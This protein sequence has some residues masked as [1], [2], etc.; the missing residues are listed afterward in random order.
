MLIHIWFSSFFVF[1]KFAR[2][3]SWVT[4]AKK[5][6]LRAS[7]AFSWEHIQF[8]CFLFFTLYFPGSFSFFG[9]SGRLLLFCT[10]PFFCSAFGCMKTFASKFEIQSYRFPVFI[11]SSFSSI[12]FFLS[13]VSPPSWSDLFGKFLVTLF[14]SWSIIASSEIC[15]C[16]LACTPFCATDFA[17]L[18]DQKTI[19][20]RLDFLLAWKW[21]KSSSVNWN[22]SFCTYSIISMQLIGEKANWMSYAATLIEIILPVN[23][24]TVDIAETQ[25]GQQTV[26]RDVKICNPQD[27]GC[28]SRIAPFDREW[29]VQYKFTACECRFDW[30]PIARFQSASVTRIHWFHPM[31]PW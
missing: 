29:N 26:F 14:S 9:T 5:N 11:R 27:D 20:D 21:V 22:I 3:Q 10:I 15:A 19:T 6:I 13:D 30:F 24:L 28:H 2:L 18:E 8:S 7:T 12:S 16:T 1:S 25:F 23:W 17:I 31:N 4:P